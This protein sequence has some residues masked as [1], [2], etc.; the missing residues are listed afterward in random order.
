MM[1]SD[2]RARMEFT[3]RRVWCVNHR[4]RP[5]LPS[6]DL[7]RPG[8]S[9]YRRAP[10]SPLARAKLRIAHLV[11]ENLRLRASSS[12]SPPTR[13]GR[14][15][16]A[17]RSFPVAVLRAAR[18]ASR[19]TSRAT[20]EDVPRLAR[21]A[22][23]AATPEPPSRARISISASSLGFHPEHLSET[24]P[25][26][27]HAPIL[28]GV[29]GAVPFV[30][31][32][33]PLAPILDPYL[34][35]ALFPVARRGEMQAAYGVTILSFLGGVHWGF[36]TS[37]FGGA[38]AV[39]LPAAT[40][41]ARERVFLAGPVRFAWSVVPSLVAWPAL[42][43]SLPYQLVTVATSLGGALA[44]DAAYAS[45][46]LTPRWLMPLRFGLTATAVVSLL[47]SVP[48][49]VETSAAAEAAEAETRRLRRDAPATREA[50]EA[51][52][53]SLAKAKAAAARAR[54]EANAFSAKLS[55]AESSAATREAEWKMVEGAR[56]AEAAA[57]RE[58]RDALAADADAAKTELA[59]AESR[60]LALEADVAASKASEAALRARVA[61]L[62]ADAKRGTGAKIDAPE[63]AKREA[64]TTA[65]EE[66]KARGG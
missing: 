16:D 60:L 56:S 46:G 52:E 26:F 11:V 25:G 20:R 57:E 27:F 66:E 50:L 12:S 24:P 6:L 58:R 14:I 21:D 39:A 31:L 43:L 29:A 18:R 63:R 48:R 30:A 42:T 23:S 4:P 34:P 54:E 19:A 32:A 37:G 3:V 44:V 53:R 9:R 35:E 51:R 1:A 8:H 41:A 49:A 45:A 2:E 5:P 28:L 13:D 55:A 10:S 17:M 65:K 33:A 38:G 22:S 62:E 64:E 40:R 61:E 7:V 47:S 15:L 59:A 36:A